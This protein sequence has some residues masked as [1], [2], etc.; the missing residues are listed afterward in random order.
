MCVL[1]FALALKVFVIFLLT[2][3]QYDMTMA[4]L[5]F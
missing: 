3:S 4:C 5:K 1:V 2:F